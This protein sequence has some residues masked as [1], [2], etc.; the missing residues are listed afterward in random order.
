MENLNKELKLLKEYMDIYIQLL[1][2]CIECGGKKI[3]KIN[4]PTFEYFKKTY[5]THY[6]LVSPN[7]IESK[8]IYDKNKISNIHTAG[9]GTS[10]GIAYR[11]YN[12]WMGCKYFTDGNLNGDYIINED[13]LNTFLKKIN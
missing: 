8:T 2:E 3:S 10:K 6:S 4:L 11:F 9:L 12:F 1:P 7:Y 13:V 5:Y